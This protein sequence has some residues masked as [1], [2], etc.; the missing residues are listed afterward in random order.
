MSRSGLQY[1]E[2][3]GIDPVTGLAVDIPSALDRTETRR[4]T[5]GGV[6]AI[7]DVVAFDTTAAGSARV[8]TVTKAA[9]DLLGNDLAVGVALE[10]SSAAGT[11]IDVA[12][13]GYVENAA[14]T[15]GVALGDGLVAS[16]VSGEV[17]TYV[18]TDTGR[19]FGVALEAEAAGTCD[20][21]LY[22]N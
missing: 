7:G 18:V 12:V 19:V 14:C 5:S 15:A 11:D 16:R 2:K 8:L 9:I 17:D 1:L 6:I 21:Y 3:T 20:I 10:V 4:F 22:G 13:R